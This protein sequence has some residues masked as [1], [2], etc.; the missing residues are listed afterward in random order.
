LTV[1]SSKQVGHLNASLLDGL[2]ASGLATQGSGASDTR[3]PDG[4]PLSSSL[5]AET[6][7]ASTGT[8]A[9]GTYFISGSTESDDFG[10]GSVNGVFCYI[11]TGP[12]ISD[13]MVNSGSMTN[14]TSTQ[15]A[16]LVVTLKTP[17]KLGYYCS[18]FDLNTDLENGGMFAIKIAHPAAGTAGF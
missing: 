13:A 12:A 10:S 11:G 14:G 18:S 9:A 4:V 17:T 5:T 2:S 8:L 7:V 1:N 3:H 15:T 16:T 6:L